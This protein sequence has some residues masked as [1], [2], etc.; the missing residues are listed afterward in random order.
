MARRQQ[1][2]PDE[3]RCDRVRRLVR[4]VG[5]AEA[6]RTLVDLLAEWVP[7]IAEREVS[8]ARLRALIVSGAVHVEGAPRRAPSLTLRAGARVEALLRLDALSSAPA[9][10]DLPFAL[11]AASILFQD[12]CLIAVDKPPGLPSH[13]TADPRRPNLVGAV[14]DYLAGQGRAT[15]LAVHQRLDRDTSGVVL[16]ATDP[17]ANE[18]LARAFAGRQAE[19]TYLA[20]SRASAP[21]GVVPPAG[22]TLTVDAPLLVSADGRV[23]VGGA[24]ARPA[25]T[26]VAV[27]ERAGAVLLLEARPATGRKHQV[28][29][30]LA[31][32][33]LPILGDTLY[34]QAQAGPLEAPRLMLHASR[35]SLPHPLSGRTLLVE[36]PVPV[37]FLRLLRQARAACQDVP[38]RRRQGPR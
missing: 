32:A 17:A 13:A 35:L 9:R 10:S 34:G 37:D 3:R 23:R 6:G 14:K 16:F 11:G 7:A 33:G 27:L 26:Q 21:A 5:A 2:Q 24:E 25:L 12:E 4:R 31:H 30:H 19:K 38:G 36:S 15:Y 8:R 1:G 22:A 20:L 29:V 18:G 28:R